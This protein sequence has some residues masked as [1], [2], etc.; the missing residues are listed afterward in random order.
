MCHYYRHLYTCTHT[1]HAFAKYCSGAAL[2]QTPCNKKNIWQAIKMSE[3]CEDCR[4][5][6][7]RS[8]AK[9][10]L[11]EEVTL[12]KKNVVKGRKVRKR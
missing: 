12:E 3:A 6:A 11:Y 10:M 9:E 8:G 5:P 1:V 7:Q 4:V 2:I